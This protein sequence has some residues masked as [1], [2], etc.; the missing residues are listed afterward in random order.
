MLTLIQNVSILAAISVVIC[1]Y[2]SKFTKVEGFSA[3]IQSWVVAIVVA[4][5]ANMLGYG[6]ESISLFTDLLNG[7]FVGLV[8]NG[9]FDIPLIKSTLTWIH[10]RTSNTDKS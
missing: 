4:F 1:E 8:A 5:I 6:F 7:L 2:L 10:A 9:L 3:Q